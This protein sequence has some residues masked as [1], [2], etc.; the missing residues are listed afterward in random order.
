MVTWWRHQMETF[1]AL[2]ALCVRN[3]LVTDEL[4]SQRPVMR[5]FDVFCDLRLN[6]R[7]SKQSRRPWFETSSHSL[8]RHGNDTIVPVGDQI[9]LFC[10]Q[11]IS[12]QTITRDAVFVRR[13]R[14]RCSNLSRNASAG[15]AQDI[16]NAKGE[17]ILFHK[18]FRAKL[19]AFPSF[20]SILNSIWRMRSSLILQ[21]GKWKKNMI[22]HLQLRFNF[23]LII[24]LQ[25]NGRSGWWMHFCRLIN[26]PG[27]GVCSV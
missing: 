22:F 21:G 13:H 14:Q 2:L 10:N 1:S 5:S 17:S 24:E 7:L 20:I 12:I 23:N 4:P 19:N 16:V 27:V 18:T 6:K 3:S 8:W 9:G 26:F 15:I 25:C 11:Q